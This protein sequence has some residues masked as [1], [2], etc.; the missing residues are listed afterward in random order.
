MTR[1][2]RFKKKKREEILLDLLKSL[3]D[4]TI[5]S[6]PLLSH[7]ELW[8]GRIADE[9]K[10]ILEDLCFCYSESL[11]DAVTE[12]RRHAKKQVRKLLRSLRR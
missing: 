7:R 5:E 10:E 2:L 12:E 9:V 1:K 4:A 6:F 3:V 8:R 11:R